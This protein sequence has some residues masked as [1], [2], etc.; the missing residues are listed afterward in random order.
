MIKN[1]N[2]Q[3]FSVLVIY[4]ILLFALAIYH[5]VNH[6]LE[7]AHL[8]MIMTGYYVSNITVGIGLH[9]LWSHNS[10]KASK[11]LEFVLMV[12]SAGTL[13]GPI[14][15]WASNHFKHHTYT[16]TDKDPHTPQKFQDNP[17]KGFLWSHIGWM[18]EGEGSYKS[19]D[20]VTMVK[21]GRNEILKF[22][23]KH[24]WKLAFFVL[25]ILPFATGYMIGGTLFY[26][27]TTFLFVGI[28]RALQQQATFCVNS[29]CH[30]FGN[31]K[32][33]NGT[34]GDIWWLALFLLGENWHN[35]HHAFPSDYRNGVKWY[36]FD[37]HKWIIYSLSKIGLAYD[38]NITDAKRIDAKVQ[39]T[40]LQN[41]EVNKTKL[42]NLQEKINDLFQN[43]QD[44]YNELESSSAA[45][46]D[47][48]K[49]SFISYQERLDILKTQLNQQLKSFDGTSEK[50]INVLSKNLKDIE[51]AMHQ[52]YADFEQRKKFLSY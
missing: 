42:Y 47:M 15:S 4:P 2:I 22:Q 12:F 11:S 40:A 19:I 46:K 39:H 18:L 52:L 23:L 24:Y 34:A 1:L 6:G 25:V 21:L 20:R 44:K 35:F 7:W 31:K 30:F 33:Y 5:G 49:N 13:Q 9:R 38:L 41:I 32:Y 28:G 10:Y 45:I 43:L 16:D 26:A 17:I 51:N 48:M 3:A 29:A 50:I 14:L 27:Y 8:I 37:V 36:H